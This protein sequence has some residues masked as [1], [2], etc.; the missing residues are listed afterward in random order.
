MKKI[1][2]TTIFVLLLISLGSC[3]NDKTPVAT[4][5][6]L[7]LLTPTAGS[8]YVLTA[9]NAGNIVATLNWEKSV[10]G[11]PSVAAYTI[12]IA[13]SGTNF[14]NVITAVKNTDQ[15]PTTTYTWTQEY[16]NSL[17]NK[18]D[19]EPCVPVD[20]DIR[21][22]STVGIAANK[23]VQ[24]SNVITVKVTPYLKD[25]P[26][27]AFATDAV[28]PVSGSKI[29]AS[30]LLQVNTDYEG[31][32]QLEPGTYK[33]FT[34][35]CGKFS[36]TD[37]SYGVNGSGS[38]VLNGTGYTVATAG[39]YYVKAN[40]ASG[41]M[42]YSITPITAFGIIGD[43]KLSNITNSLPAMTY[44]DVTANNVTTKKWRIVIRLKGGNTFK[45]RA[46]NSD[47]INL[48][49]GDAGQGS[50]D[51]GGSEMRH[52]GSGFIVPIVTGLP[53]NTYTVLLDLNTPRAYTYTLTKQ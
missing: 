45:F 48:G 28:G 21:I 51:Y 52:N 42:S 16:L 25:L 2:K 9:E 11:T 27:I 8:N 50:S 43:A 35:Q 46:N 30:G 49:S 6:G 38:L 15:S 24:Y 7:K 32:M 41:I 31:F 37:P 23:L 26:T 3:T 13:K 29:A 14:A 39:F 53:N 44:V 22:K 40:I 34:S 36:A 47:L 33:F 18:P 12:E 17:L 20:I 1:L 4:A 19:F 5:Q 10:D